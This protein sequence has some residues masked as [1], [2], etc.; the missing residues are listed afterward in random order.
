MCNFLVVVT[1]VYGVFHSGQ[2]L[3]SSNTDGRARSATR[4]RVTPIDS[5]PPTSFTRPSE[6]H[7]SS[8]TASTI[9]IGSY[10]S[11]SQNK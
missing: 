1:F 8:I 5:A 4:G 10:E 6:M 7:L 2:D 3:E 11:L 9:P